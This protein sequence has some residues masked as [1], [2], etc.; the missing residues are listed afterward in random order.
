MTEQSIKEQTST[1]EEITALA[2]KC[3]FDV[4]P[5]SEFNSNGA[6]K[7][8]LN[9]EQKMKISNFMSQLPSVMSSTAMANAYIVKFPEGLPHVLGKLKS[10]GYF[11]AIPGEDGKFVGQA[12]LFPMQ[13]QAATLAVFSA[14]SIATGQY[15]LTLINKELNL[16]NKKMD[17]ILNFLYGSKKSELIAEVVF[18]QDALKNY[19]SIMQSDPHRIATIA[20]LQSARKTAMEDIEFYL[21]TIFEFADLDEKDWRKFEEIREKASA[22]KSNLEISL[23]LYAMASVCEVYFSENFDEEYVSYV[24]E[25]AANYILRCEKSL[26]VCY[27]K[28]AGK[29]AYVNGKLEDKKRIRSELEEIA[30]KYSSSEKSQLQKAVTEIL[31]S[32]TKPT[33]YYLTKSGEVYVKETA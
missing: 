23:Q 18:V 13:A 30:V 11:G 33:E 16:I 25:A 24:R 6:K 20:G 15:F 8:V 21:H 4:T 3:D 31:D 5:C 19:C 2:E 17:E 1:Q 28:L 32:V 12:A 7:L 9:A 29:A 26:G 27:G 22:S 14:M 10:G